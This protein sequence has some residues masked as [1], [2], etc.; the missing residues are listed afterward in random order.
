MSP[1]D[2]DKTLAAIAL[3]APALRDAGVTGRVT[4]GDIVFELDAPVPVPQPTS[5]LPPVD[6]PDTYGG[7]M[8]QR[9]RFD[10][11]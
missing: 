4:I 6:D 11:E 10:E 8:P 3:R 7:E 9:R 1:D 5:D 2:L